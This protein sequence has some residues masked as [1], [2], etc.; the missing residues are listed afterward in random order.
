MAA[1]TLF[2]PASLA[3]VRPP[4]RVKDIDTPEDWQRAEYLYAALR[5]GGELP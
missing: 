1:E 4:W 5:A 3:L 2:G